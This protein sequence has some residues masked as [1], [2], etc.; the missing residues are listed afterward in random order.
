MFLP[1]AAL[2]A[3]MSIRTGEFFLAD[4][5]PAHAGIHVFLLGTAAKCRFM[6]SLFRH[7]FPLLF[8]IVPIVLAP[9]EF[10]P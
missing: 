5:M 1:I 7:C 8:A 4:V 10:R 2:D 3:K 9:F 6:A